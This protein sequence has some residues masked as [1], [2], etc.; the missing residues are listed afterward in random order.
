MISERINTCFSLFNACNDI[1]TFI[2]E[3]MTVAQDVDK[4]SHTDIQ[5]L[6]KSDLD[7]IPDVN[8]EWYKIKARI[9]AIERPTADYFQK[10]LISVSALFIS[11]Y[12]ETILDKNNT[13]KDLSLKV[14]SYDYNYILNM[15]ASVRNNEYYIGDIEFDNSLQCLDFLRN[16]LLHGDYHIVDNE[17]CLTKDGK[18]GTILFDKLIDFCFVLSNL[19]KCKGKTLED[20]MV[21]YSPFHGFSTTLKESLINRVYCVDFKFTVKGSRTFNMN[22]LKI[23]EKIENLAMTYNLSGKMFVSEAV[24]MAINECSEEIAAAK[25]KVEYSIDLFKNKP[26]GLDII[27]SFIKEY[28]K[29][30]DKKSLSIIDVLNYINSNAFVN[31]KELLNNSYL[32]LSQF[33]LMFMTNA[34]G[35]T[36]KNDVPNTEM[37]YDYTYVLPF[38]ILKFYCYYNYGLDQIFSDGITTN[39]REILE[40]K[41]FDYSQLDL[42]LFEDP[43]MTVEHT[44]TSYQDQVNG[45]SNEYNKTTLA[46][47]NALNKYNGFKNR[48]GNTKPDIE[49]KLFGICEVIKNNLQAIT[50]LQNKA[51]LFDFNKYVRNLNIINHLRNSIA[52]GN[53]E[54]DDSNPQEK[55]YIFKD[56]YNGVTTYSLRV[57]VKDFEKLFDYKNMIKDYFDNLSVSTIGKS[58]DR[59]RMEEMLINSRYVKTECLDTWNNLV[60]VALDSDDK[61]LIDELYLTLITMKELNTPSI[62]IKSYDKYSGAIGATIASVFYYAMMNLDDDKRIT[63]N[64]Y[65]ISFKTY[66]NIIKYVLDYA[67]GIKE[68]EEFFK[69]NLIEECDENSILK[70]YYGRGVGL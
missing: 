27:N 3:T 23:K 21:L 53:Y 69:E 34:T 48:F 19:S 17:I 59:L 66:K 26:N 22:I 40:G 42:S 43:N 54:L 44:I 41:K 14:N 16:K 20:S 62:Y 5:K 12:K 56:I 1:E 38:N 11:L 46:Y 2:K 65:D 64:G 45:I 33:L 39:L 24:E 61:Y 57:K 15:V 49:S 47:Q 29:I 70:E 60:N 36:V 37:S 50:N 18:Q 8:A 51:N 28:K 55:Y 68:Y 52:H 6:K 58:Y 7:D 31:N 10:M 67:N 9:N 25:C 32:S 63:F 4:L 30:D 13:S 35:G